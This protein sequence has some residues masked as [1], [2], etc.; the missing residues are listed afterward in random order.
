MR[1]GA[2]R[3]PCGALHDISLLLVLS[4]SRLPIQVFSVAG[5]MKYKGRRTSHGFSISL[6]WLHRTFE[7]FFRPFSSVSVLPFIHY[8]RPKA[9]QN[10]NI[11][12][13]EG[14]HL[15]YYATTSI[16][17]SWGPRFL[18][19]RYRDSHHPI[20]CYYREKGGAAT[21]R[22]LVRG[23]FS[24]G[25]EQSFITSYF[26]L[27]ILFTRISFMICPQSLRH[28]RMMVSHVHSLPRILR[29]TA[30]LLLYPYTSFL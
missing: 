27:S 1:P 17:H 10:I 6:Y 3:T 13:K 23:E 16:I 30:F 19:T 20:C 8:T 2:R 21:R 25:S 22:R 24:P 5:G 28:L 4:T 15:V 26:S 7:F 29:N 11:I 9:L 14:V 12:K 18:Y